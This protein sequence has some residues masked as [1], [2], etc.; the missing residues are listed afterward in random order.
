M[1]MRINNFLIIVVLVV[2]KY[3]EVACGSLRIK[4]IEVKVE[5]KQAN[6]PFGVLFPFH[7]Y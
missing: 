3:M 2:A 6:T 4:R 5:M 1:A 7:F